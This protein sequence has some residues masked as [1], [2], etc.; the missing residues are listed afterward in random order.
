[1][2]FERVDL[3]WFPH[4][5]LSVRRLEISAPA[6]VRGTAAAVDVRLAF[7]PLLRGHVRLSSVLVDRPDLF[8]EIPAATKAEIP[9]PETAPQSLIEPLLR[10][11]TS[12][13]GGLALEIRRGRI[14]VVRSGKVL[15]NV[16]GLSLRTALSA[17]KSGSLLGEA[18]IQ[19]SSLSFHRG[20]RRKLDLRGFEA[21][22]A[23]HSGNGRA[24]ATLS[25]LSL[26]SPRLFVEG[27][28]RRESTPSLVEVDVK[29]RDLDVARLR[30]QLL[31]FAGDS[32]PVPE[33]FAILRGGELAS[34]SF[35]ASGSAPSDLGTLERMTIRAT[36]SGGSVRIASAGLDLDDVR[37]DVAVEGSV[38]SAE[39]VTARI[40]RSEARNGRVRIGLARGDD[41]LRVEAE[42]RAHLPEIP[43]VL[44]RAIR[45]ESLQRELSL[46]E[47]LEGSAR[48]RVVLETRKR[49]LRTD[50]R[51]SEMRLSARYRRIPFPVRIDRAGFSYDGDRVGLTDVRG[52]IG[53]STLSD[54][55]VRARL[56]GSPRIEKVTGGFD[57]SLDE[58]FPWVS[59]GEGMEALRTNVRDLRG[60]A[61]L[62]VAALAGP[63][64]RP[65]EW[66]GEATGALSDLRFDTPLFPSPIGIGSGRFEI[67]GDAARVTGLEVRTMDGAY[68]VSGTLR[69][70]REG[71]RIE[72]VAD[73]EAGPETVRWVWRRAA[74][75]ADLRPAAP[76]ALHQVRVGLAGGGSLSLDG[77][78]GVPG[79]AL[80]TLGLGGGR[81]GL[82]RLDLSVADGD[83]LASVS[84]WR[85]DDALA[86]RYE[87]HLEAA[88]LDKLLA[89]PRAPRG[90][91]AGEFLALVPRA[92][93][94][95][96][97]ADGRL[98]AAGLE[99]PTPVGKVAVER[100]GLRAAG[101]RLTVDSLS[102]VWN[103]Q[104][105]SAS[106]GAT[107]RDGVLV[108][109]LDVTAEALSWGCV[110]DAL[111][112][113]KKENLAAQAPPPTEMTEKTA[114]APSG[115]P[116][117]GDVRI[118]VGSFTVGDL[119]WAPVLGEVRLED[120]AVTTT[121]REARI[122]GISTNGS[123]RFGEG[124]RTKVR[125]EVLAAG[126]DIGVP[127]ACLGVPGLQM[128][129][130]F[131]ARLEVEAEGEAAELPRV[132]RGPV[133]LKASKGRFGKATLLTKILA[134]LH[135]TSVF[136][137]KEER[138][139]IGQAMAFDA[140]T[141][142]GSLE[143]GRV[144]I[145][146]GVLKT[147]GFTM[148]ASGT[149]G[150]VDRS[151]D[152]VVLAHPFSTADRIIQAIPVVRYI[153]GK[154]LLAVAASVTGSLAEPKI[155][156]TPG[157]DVSR[158]VV[159]ILGRTVTLP[160]KVFDPEAR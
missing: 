62:S 41:T 141:I 49:A 98:E 155:G 147:P 138:D 80:A 74:L 101:S 18:R 27:R 50:I 40:L 12:E 94:G 57:L 1:M 122:C 81:G 99:L 145:R 112:G 38:L 8:V 76:L 139:Q 64:S 90:R 92:G 97:T 24:E 156:V 121:V 13:A 65:L 157:R 149:I 91:I 55:D 36:L 2:R 72:A 106:G 66:R 15:T 95:G 10:S 135:G 54:V 115:L 83:G 152:L 129:G 5:S 107:L 35:R 160:V 109:D 151:V 28:L 60:S 9:A 142:G 131:E 128:S 14:E 19:A 136:A 23:F 84:L 20:E 30:G 127:L 116:V 48:G 126:P 39:G 120:D 29:G 132:A 6:K 79:G 70:F 146:E 150:Y 25:L 111:G 105:V 56:G 53:G 125:G 7:L 52:S 47:E 4:P 31:G 119:A 140:L 21:E 130:A 113:G 42:V 88:T 85:E 77:A 104:R 133:T 69:G 59:S 63:A 61:R 103:E 118:S 102:V 100:L 26:E 68:R 117:R 82:D 58:L 123:A 137:G 32:S 71:L 114:A 89:V 43:G 3:S 87:G 143:S 51:I 22:G 75:P 44:S 144:A 158:G 78:F 153:L 154:D 16:D 45:D 11:Y 110:A 46:V 96:M 67:G 17:G 37:G 124:G 108:L 159:D 34:F 73:G 93:P 33:I 134:V 86:I 148:A